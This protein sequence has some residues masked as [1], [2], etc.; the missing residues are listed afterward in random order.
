LKNA[1]DAA[2]DVRRKV[3]SSA[4]PSANGTQAAPIAAIRHGRALALPPRRQ[5]SDGVGKGKNVAVLE[6]NAVVAFVT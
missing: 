6:F 2:F 5:A 1:C 3:D 4:A